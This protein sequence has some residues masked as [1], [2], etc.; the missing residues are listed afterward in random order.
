MT[1]RWYRSYP[2]LGMTQQCVVPRADNVNVGNE[3]GE[4]FVILITSFPFQERHKTKWNKN[5][6]S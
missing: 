5:V 3:A 4:A 2:F 1:E 6:N